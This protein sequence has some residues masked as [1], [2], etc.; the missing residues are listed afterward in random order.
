MSSLF[1]QD[2]VFVSFELDL[3]K[4]SKELDLFLAHGLDVFPVY[5][6]VFLD[7]HDLLFC[8]SKEIRKVRQLARD[9]SESTYILRI[10]PS[11]RMANSLSF[12]TNIVNGGDIT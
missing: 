12:I 5:L 4:D 1:N 9:Q 7:P 3:S 10:C 8:V 6:R 2:K 11:L